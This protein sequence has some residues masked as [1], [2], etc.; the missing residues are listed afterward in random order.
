[1]DIGRLIYRELLEAVE[2]GLITRHLAEQIFTVA[3]STTV[4]EFKQHLQTYYTNYWIKEHILGMLS[5]QE[6]VNKVL[7][8]IL[9]KLAKTHPEALTVVSRLTK[10]PNLDLLAK[11]I[12]NYRLT[13]G[14]ELTNQ[15][16][17]ILYKE[18]GPALETKLETKLDVDMLKS[19]TK[20]GSVTLDQDEEGLLVTLYYEPMECD[21][22][23]E[24]PND[25]EN[26][27]KALHTIEA[28]RVD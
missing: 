21:F 11:E 25:V 26:L 13:L 28:L 14:S 9:E 15:M 2:Q 16:L 20:Y 4:E 10:V 8:E 5:E 3:Q 18:R 19:L 22:N 23:C 1:M 24:T 12:L 17:N 27:L 7:E 6:K